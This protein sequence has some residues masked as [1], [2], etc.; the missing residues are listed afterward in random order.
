MGFMTLSI[1]ISITLVGSKGGWPKP[2]NTT[3]SLMHTLTHT[4][5]NAQIRW[6]FTELLDWS[7]ADTWPAILAHEKLTYAHPSTHTHKALS[8][9]LSTFTLSFL[10]WLQ[11]DTG[12]K[13]SRG[14]W[15]RMPSMLTQS[16]VK[17]RQSGS[18]DCIDPCEQREVSR[19]RGEQFDW[20]SLCTRGCGL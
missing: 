7:L 10:A 14:N 15:N 2:D 18:L 20:Q 19:D 17:G 16:R 12:E 9:C 4:I 5:R 6:C 8:D 13:C 3:L 11:W 1:Y